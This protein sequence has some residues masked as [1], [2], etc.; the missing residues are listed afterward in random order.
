MS[1]A[2]P[3]Y[4]LTEMKGKYE[5]R[6]DLS[7]GAYNCENLPDFG[8]YDIT[9]R[10]GRLLPQNEGYEIKA[11]SQVVL[12]CP[13]KT[14]GVHLTVCAIPGAP[15]GDRALMVTAK[16]R[17]A[18]IV[19]GKWTDRN[20]SISID[21][22]SAI[23]SIAL[24]TCNKSP[25]RITACFVLLKPEQKKKKEDN[26]DNDPDPEPMHIDSFPKADPKPSD[27]KM[28]SEGCAVCLEDAGKIERCILMPCGHARICMECAARIK[29][30]PECRQPV[31]RHQRV[32]I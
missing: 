29:N 15:S 24:G 5:S 17:G 32:F 20:L 27:H 10:G 12:T 26:A 13:P 9:L 28:S 3:P 1:S 7:W 23:E 30:C 19:A 4:F 22:Q 16:S 8:Q 21:P 2:T 25:S 18:S 31:Q 14:V 6:A 11:G